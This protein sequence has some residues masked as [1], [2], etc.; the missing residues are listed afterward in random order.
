MD[1]SIY[2]YIW[3]KPQTFHATTQK[4]KQRLIST[5]RGCSSVLLHQGEVDVQQI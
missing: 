1:I 4:E 3:M 2:T 5:R